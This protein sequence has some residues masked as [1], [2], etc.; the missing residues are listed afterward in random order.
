MKKSII[1]FVG[2]ILIVALSLALF[3]SGINNDDNKNISGKTAVPY[4]SI[5]DKLTAYPYA[6]FMGVIIKNPLFYDYS[7]HMLMASSSKLLYLSN[8]NQRFP[9]EK[10]NTI[11]DD[12]KCVEYKLD[13]DGDLKHAYVFFEKDIYYGEMYF[14][15]PDLSSEF[16]SDLSSG[17][18]ISI[19]G[20]N[21]FTIEP[22]HC[23]FLANSPFSPDFDSSDF[24]GFSENGESTEFEE[25][26]QEE[27]LLLKDGIMVIDFY[28]DSKYDSEITIKDLTF[29]K[30]GEKS[31]FPYNT[32]LLISNGF[33]PDF[34]KK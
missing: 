24:T 20:E 7:Q 10:V 21:P 27:T 9:I 18:T 23:A 3:A 25:V 17:S 16:F 15:Y 31:E 34:A 8:F 11:N 29:I 4:D 2:V 14:A 13:K 28:Y 30:Y 1:F 6:S 19:K 26:W 32:S 5:M 33:V 22:A 12:V